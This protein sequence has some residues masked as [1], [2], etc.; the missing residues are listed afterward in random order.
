MSLA[1]SLGQCCC[2]SGGGGGG[3]TCSS[4]ED[5]LK[6]SISLNDDVISWKGVSFTFA[7]GCDF[8]NMDLSSAQV[9]GKHA[10]IWFSSLVG[11]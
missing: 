1:F 8:P 6:E 7:Q 3:D 4:D 10:R 2:S 5:T 11:I 9:P